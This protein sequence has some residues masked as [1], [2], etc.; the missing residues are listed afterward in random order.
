V[1]L[2]RENIFKK[3]FFCSA[4]QITEIYLKIST[5][6]PNKL[7]LLI[8]GTRFLQSNTLLKSV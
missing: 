1:E 2:T 5:G 7:S 6:N 4:V 3:Y 8:R